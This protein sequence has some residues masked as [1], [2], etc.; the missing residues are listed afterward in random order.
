MLRKRQYDF[1]RSK[2]IVKKHYKTKQQQKEDCEKENECK[3]SDQT[4]TDDVDKPIGV[5][6]DYDLIKERPE[7]RRTVDFRNKLILSPLTTVGNLPFRRICKEFGADIT[8]GEMACAVPIINGLSQEWSLV[9]RHKSEDVFGVQIC[10]N[11]SELITYAAQILREKCEIDFIDLNI[12]CPIELIY[13]QGG[14]SA[15]IRRT[16]VLETIVRSCSE[17]LDGTPFTVKTRTGIYADKSVAH[18]LVPKFESWGAAAVTIHGR[19][20]EQRY[21]KRSDWNYIEQCAQQ[22]KRIPIIG[23]GDILSFDDYNEVRQTA[24]SVSSVMLGRGALIKPWIFKEIKEQKP[25][26]ISSS[27]RYDILRKYVNYGLEH[28]GTD[29]QGV[30]TTRR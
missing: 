9:R 8:C 14:G 18:E 4:S 16:N 6:S 26:D 15:L 1:S 23:N 3:A 28:W 29:T 24:P 27:E 2:A 10:G 17:V 5:C 25:Y 19:S 20:R 11:S 22:A 12:G 7:E 30:E 21:T 13:S